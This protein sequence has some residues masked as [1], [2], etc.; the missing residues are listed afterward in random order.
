MY[1]FTI[2]CESVAELISKDLHCLH[3]QKEQ[4]LGGEAWMS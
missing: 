1:F 4:I 2:F 3:K